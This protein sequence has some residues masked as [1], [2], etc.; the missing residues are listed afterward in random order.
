MKLIPYSVQF[1][2][3]FINIV[4]T[5]LG[6]S[7]LSI[8]LS[9]IASNISSQMK[10]AAF[11]AKKEDQELSDISNAGIEYEEQGNP[12]KRDSPSEDNRPITGDDSN[13]GKK[14]GSTGDSP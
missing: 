5:L 13:G 2:L 11:L 10:K 9:L 4:L 3:V 1:Q 8:T 6:L 7:F 14:Y 12:Q